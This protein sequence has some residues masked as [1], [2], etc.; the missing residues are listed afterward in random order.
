MAKYRE[1]ICRHYIAKGV[2]AKNRKAEHRGYCQRCT[3][4]I[5]RAKRKHK[6][7]K[8]EKLRNLKKRGD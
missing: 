8:L 1:E 7:A 5:P 6:N 2:C 4:Y 3:K